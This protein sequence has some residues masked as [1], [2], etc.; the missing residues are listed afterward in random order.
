MKKIRSLTQL[1]DAIDGDLSGRKR[2]L[3]N[4]KLTVDGAKDSRRRAIGLSAVCLLYGNWEGFVKFAGTCYVNYVHHQ[5]VPLKQLNDGLTCIYLRSHMRGL[6][7]SK[8]ISLHRNFVSLMRDTSDS[9]LSL[10]TKAAIETY[11]NLNF[12]VLAEITCIIGCDSR[13]YE[14]K[15]VQIDEKLLRHRNSIAHNGEDPTFDENEYSSIHT[16]V[17]MLLEKFRDDVE[18]AAA[19]SAFKLQ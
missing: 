11:D 17:I 13:W 12:E 4:L 16:E 1:N 2:M 5:G 10:P 8:K 15:K 19:S 9:P 7:D 6:R 18:N 3:T 14:T